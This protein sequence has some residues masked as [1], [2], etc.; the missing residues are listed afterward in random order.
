MRTRIYFTPLHMGG[1]GL[2]SVQQSS[3]SNYIALL[4]P[5]VDQFEFELCG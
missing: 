4:D 2:K 1:D 3:A 5:Q